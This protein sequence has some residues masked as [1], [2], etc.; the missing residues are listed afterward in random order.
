MIE[1][2]EHTA[3]IGIRIRS[4]SLEGL[5]K[6]AAFGLLNIM[7]SFK[8]SDYP[9]EEEILIK[10]E[11]EDMEELLVTWLNEILYLFE[12]KGYAFRNVE[13]SELSATGLKAKLECFKVAREE[14]V[15]YIKAATYHNLSLRRADDGS[16]EAVIIFDI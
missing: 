11:A 14:I 6:E 12:S 8:R 5:F 15:C 13:I 3:D 2:I 10:V 7:F 4:E 9:L 16:F 1:F